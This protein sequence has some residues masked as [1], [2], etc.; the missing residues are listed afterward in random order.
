MRAMPCR[1]STPQS[2]G[3]RSEQLIRWF[4]AEVSDNPAG[5]DDITAKNSDY[6]PPLDFFSQTLSH[7]LELPPAEGLEAALKSLEL[8]KNLESLKTARSNREKGLHPPYNLLIHGRDD[9]PLEIVVRPRPIT[10]RLDA[11]RVRQYSAAVAHQANR[12]ESRGG[13]EERFFP[14]LLNQ[15]PRP[16][17]LLDKTGRLAEINETWKKLLPPDW[18]GTDSDPE[19]APVLLKPDHDPMPAGDLAWNRAFVDGKSHENQM[20][21]VLTQ[22]RGLIWMRISATPIESVKF[23]LIVT[24]M[25]ITEQKAAE[26]TLLE[27]DRRYQLA[28]E[29]GRLGF[30]EWNLETGE[31]HLDPSLKYML[32]LSLIHI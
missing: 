8:P 32:G 15:F 25:D 11:G 14:S 3:T 20:V 27:S 5:E 21:G 7:I 19:E 29:T 9:T 6:Y 16:A 30:W 12:L 24:C 28:V 17:A 26:E 4:L 23:S 31:F 10:T 22:E 18:N 13:W 2:E 1:L